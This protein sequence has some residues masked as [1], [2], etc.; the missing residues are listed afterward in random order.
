MS[1]RKPIYLFVGDDEHPVM[2]AARQ[3]VDALV[4]PAEQAFGLEIIEGRA[5]NRD[6]AAGTIKR[7]RDALATPGFLLSQGKVVWWR[8]V[9]FLADAQVSAT[10]EVKTELKALAA[11]L[12]SGQAGDSTLLVTAP[13]ADK[14]TAFYKLCASR[15]EVREFF[16]PD[17]PY[18]VERL[19]REKIRAALKE[20]GLSAAED[21]VEF[22]L[23]RIG[24]DSRQIAM[25]IE[26]V[27]L[28]VTG[29]NQVTMKDAQA[30]VSSSASAVMWDLLDAVGER[31]LPA[32]LGI[33]RDLLAAKESSIGI[34]VMLMSRMRELVLYRE[35]LDKGWLTVRGGGGRETVEWGAVPEDAELVLSS[36]L[37]R[38]PR[39]VHPFVAG[40]LCRQARAYSAAAL[41]RNQR[42][43]MR[44]YE[45]LVSSRISESTVMELLLVRLTR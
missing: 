14:R 1:N 23:A 19:G 7:C 12:E 29:R 18:L 6:D 13:G 10:D 31:R 32:A 8:S 27:S 4:S 36:V 2:A 42:I 33:L 44:S 20:K 17:K 21:V 38:D 25:E 34:T 37:K 39:T 11:V 15:G 35:A 26:K 16:L 24:A 22:M 3:T 30:V 41:R 5:D 9:S 43:L 45:S 40:K 28:F